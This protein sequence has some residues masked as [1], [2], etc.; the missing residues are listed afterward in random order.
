MAEGAGLVD[1]CCANL[2]LRLQ[3]FLLP[4]WGACPAL[5][6]LFLLGVA[7]PSFWLR[8]SYVP[9]PPPPANAIERG[10]EFR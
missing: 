10:V 2:L 1:V 9:L 4:P 5:R 7:R 8:P 3:G 6:G